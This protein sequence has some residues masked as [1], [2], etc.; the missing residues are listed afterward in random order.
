MRRLVRH[1]KGEIGSESGGAY[2]RGG[3]H[4]HTEKGAVLI[5]A[6]VYITVISV[7]VATLTGWASNNLNNTTKF[8]NV[9][10]EHYALS[11]A[12]DT[13]IESERYTPDPSSPTSNPTSLGQCWAPSGAYQLPVTGTLD[14][15][16]I[17]VWCTTS[18]NLVSKVTRTLTAYACPSSVSMAN[19]QLTPSLTAIVEFDDY[20]SPEGPQLLLQCNLQGSKECGYSETFLSW[21]WGGDT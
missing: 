2:D 9:S 18:I 4:R 5:L 21:E 10:E 16:V 7:M 19:C 20:P 13:A 3:K 14:G 15:Y 8:Q 6:L 17:S 1:V 12:M 11:S